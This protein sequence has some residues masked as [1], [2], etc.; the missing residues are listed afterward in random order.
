MQL[1]LKERKR[2]EDEKNIFP[3]MLKDGF[4]EAKKRLQ[5]HF[6]SKFNFNK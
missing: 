4:R 6:P 1:D 5:S 2:Q 3:I